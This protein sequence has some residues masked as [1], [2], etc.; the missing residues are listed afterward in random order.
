MT[1]PP[2]VP[3]PELVSIL[4]RTTRGV[5]LAVRIILDLHESKSTVLSE[6]AGLEEDIDYYLEETQAMQK[7]VEALANRFLLHLLNNPA[8]NDELKYIIAMALQNRIDPMVLAKLWNVS[9]V[10]EIIRPL[11][12]KYSF[13]ATGDLH[14]TVREFLRRHWR[15]EPILGLEEVLNAMEK[16]INEL[17]PSGSKSDRDYFEWE[18]KRLNIK[19]WKNPDAVINDAERL[20]VLGLAFEHPL[21]EIGNLVQELQKYSDKRR[22][23]RRKMYGWITQDRMDWRIPEFAKS[24]EAV[25]VS[26]W[27]SIEKASKDLLIGLALSDLNESNL[28]AKKEHT[29]ATYYFKKALLVLRD[30]YPRKHEVITRYFRSIYYIS[31]D[32]NNREIVSEGYDWAIKQ[33]LSTESYAFEYANLLHNLGRYEE[34]VAHYVQ[35]RENDPEN[36]LAHWGLIHTYHHHLKHHEETLHACD[37]LLDSDTNGYNEAWIIAT[38]AEA[39]VELKRFGEAEKAYRDGIGLHEN[40]EMKLGLANLLR[41]QLDRP[42]EAT[43]LLDAIMDYELDDLNVVVQLL[44]CYS[45]I[46]KDVKEH[47]LLDKAQSMAKKVKESS[48][49]ND[50][51]WKI[52]ES[53]KHLK[54]AKYIAT[55]ANEKGDATIHALHTLVAIQI[56]LREWKSCKEKY[57]IWINQVDSKDMESGWSQFVPMFTDLKE[58][59]LC[60]EAGALIGPREPSDFWEPL[61]WAVTNS[62]EPASAHHQQLPHQY[63]TRANKIMVQICDNT[64]IAEITFPSIE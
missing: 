4:H 14:P 25:N 45:K 61:R 10:S 15:F 23:D 39:L 42:E 47:H 38:K 5:P 40:P 17:E 62:C 51:A 63:Q 48:P 31:M 52:Y 1:V 41:D 20:Y 22:T 18:I 13:I 29:K 33:G 58:Q 56:R 36:L 49:L 9:N 37:E 3:D 55:L 11:S 24:L 50:A 28:D 57:E 19:G 8:A 12:K 21:E 54:V 46:G 64:S 32:G 7:V 44:N 26:G 35:A 53:G 16:A 60:T 43:E 6:L 59:G 34:S 30:D 2:V 27:S